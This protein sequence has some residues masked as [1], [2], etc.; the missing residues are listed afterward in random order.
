MDECPWIVLS[1][2]TFTVTSEYTELVKRLFKSVFNLFVGLEL[3]SILK[4]GTSTSVFIPIEF[5]T[6]E[7]GTGEFGTSVARHGSE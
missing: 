2:D 1:L 4:K 3:S 5:G 6:S 7:L